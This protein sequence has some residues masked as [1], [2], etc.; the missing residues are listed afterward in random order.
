MTCK[1][2][3]DLQQ[4]NSWFWKCYLPCSKPSWLGILII[5]GHMQDNSMSSEWLP[6]RIEGIW[7][8]IQA[9]NS[10]CLEDFLDGKLICL[11]SHP[12]LFVG[13]KTENITKK[14]T[15]LQIVK[16]D[17]ILSILKWLVCNFSLQD[18][19]IISSKQ[20]KGTLKL[21]W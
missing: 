11:S 1:Q 20:V 16:W 10:S 6:F 15:N 21:N 3:K 7:G 19:C 4:G 12:I 13:W 2:R 18:P 14:Q 9:C 5:D 8:F 17:A